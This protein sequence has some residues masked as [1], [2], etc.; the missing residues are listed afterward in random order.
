MLR[1]NSPTDMANAAKRAGGICSERDALLHK[2][3]FAI[4]DYGRAIQVLELRQGVLPKPDY[5]LIRDAADRYRRLS[6]EICNEL[7]R[8]IATHGC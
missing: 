5:V 8:H 2:Y 3:Q 6:E 4:S 7:D 1:H